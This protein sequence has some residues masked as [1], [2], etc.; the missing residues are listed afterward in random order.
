MQRISRQNN[1]D[2][3][4]MRDKV[5]KPNITDDNSH[6]GESRKS[7]VK[8]CPKCL[9]LF[10][11]NHKCH[12]GWT[13]CTICGLELFREIK[14]TGHSSL[15]KHYRVINSLICNNC[16]CKIVRMMKK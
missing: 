11:K 6:I 12:N 8:Q 5:K 2:G 1:R 4:G 15:K 10:T 7:E 13:Y 16:A 3:S 14:K 9:Q